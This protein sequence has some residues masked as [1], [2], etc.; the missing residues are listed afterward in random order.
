MR[1]ILLSAQGVLF[2]DRW[3]RYYLICIV[4][5][6]LGV[7]V[8]SRFYALH[9]PDPVKYQKMML[10]LLVVCGLFFILTPR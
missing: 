1:G 3:W 8:G 2:L 10:V 9:K 6:G 4:A 7:L 5:G